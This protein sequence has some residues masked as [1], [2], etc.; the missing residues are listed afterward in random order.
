MLTFIIYYGVYIGN[1]LGDYDVTFNRTFAIGNRSTVIGSLSEDDCARLCSTGE[2]GHCI[3]FSYCTAS[4]T[5][6][7]YRGPPPLLGPPQAKPF[8]NIYIGTE[9]Y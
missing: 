9:I 3:V 5:C 6:I 8:C 1:Y 7:L 4:S 2:N